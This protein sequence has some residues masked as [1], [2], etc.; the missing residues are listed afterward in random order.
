V[1]ALRSL[2]RVLTSGTSPQ[3]PAERFDRAK[4]H[5]VD[6]LGARLTGSQTDEGLAV[7]RAAAALGD[8]L[9]QT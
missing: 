3:L 9:I 6:T 5:I 2:A 7:G 1:K 8:N 4:R